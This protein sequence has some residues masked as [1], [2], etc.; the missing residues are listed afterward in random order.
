MATRVDS[1]RA[2]R[3]GK[4]VYST[5]LFTFVSGKQV[6]GYV[7]GYNTCLL[8]QVECYELPPDRLPTP[9]VKAISIERLKSMSVDGHT[10]ESLFMRGKPMKVLAEN[11]AT[12]G[13]MEIFGYAK[14]KHDM[15]VPIPLPGG[16]G[17]FVSTGTHEKYYWYVRTGGGELQE[18]PRGQ[19][20]FVELMSKLC[21]KAPA[22]AAE[23]QQ[24]AKASGAN[25]PRYRIDNAPELV[26][27]YNSIVAGN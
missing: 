12:P 7:D 11:L 25:K 22:L 4:P 10:L 16:G 2:A 23:L 19:K 5:A 17:I 14:T 13:P 8:D 15:L 3:D 20:A 27:Q 9:P 6:R 21:S 26:S 24:S 1:L 18:L